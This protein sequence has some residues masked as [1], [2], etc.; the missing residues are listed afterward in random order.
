MQFATFS[1]LAATFTI[2]AFALSLSSNFQRVI[3]LWGEKVQVSVYLEDDIPAKDLQKLK[4]DLG[5]HEIV[6]AVEYISKDRAAD[7]FKEQMASYAPDLMDDSEF[8]TP[9]PASLIAQIKDGKSGGDLQKIQSMA[10]EFSQRAG[11]EDVSYGQS[12]IQNYTAFVRI[13]QAVGFAIIAVLLLGSLFV[14]ANSIR[15]LVSSR[16]EEVE[17]FELI[18]ATPRHI[19]RPY[20]VEGVFLGA[21]SALLALVVNFVFYQWQV[22]LMKR[23]LAFARVAAEFQYLSIFQIVLFILGAAVLGG[24]GAWLTVRSLNDGWSAARGATA[25]ARI[26]LMAVGSVLTVSS[27]ASQ[28]SAQADVGKIVDQVREQREVLN[29]AETERR[30]LLGSIYA[31]NQRMKKI[32]SDKGKL[33]NDLIHAQ[34]SVETVAT[35]IKSLESHLERQ[36]KNLRIR[37]RAL[38][39]VSGEPMIG[40]VFSASNSHEF[41]TMMRNLKIIS[42]RDFHLIRSY[43]LNLRVLAQQRE[44]LKSQVER[45]LTVERRIKRQERLLEQEYRTKTDLA[46]RIEKETRDRKQE[47]EQLRKKVSLSSSD[48]E[49]ARVLRPSIYEKKGKL[50]MPLPAGDLVREFGLHIDETYK[51]KLSHKGWLLRAQPAA[52]VVATE[53]GS[54]VFAGKFHGYGNTMIV[55]HGDHY[56]S[57]YAGLSGLNASVGQEVA[58][59]EI[60]GR[61]ERDLYFE[62]RHFSEPENPISWISSKTPIQARMATETSSQQGAAR[63]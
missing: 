60:L 30:K 35:S 46:S 57:V 7:L 29:E 6:A 3:S 42:D 52:T 33:T 2:V 15:T 11:V 1:V 40:A 51:T 23:S 49:L 4:E 44:K 37:L 27:F 54:V 62:F 13:V 32:A 19:R 26:A 56:Y 10:S 22:A 5:R 25:R 16:R 41:D 20:L 61:V 21:T 63:W 43:R 55:D 58:R 36:R 38:Y 12:W 34:D 50:L 45:L 28:A 48:V 39:K 17:I 9:F 47:I 8:A 14:I 53:E 31:V 59:G 24:L 18:G